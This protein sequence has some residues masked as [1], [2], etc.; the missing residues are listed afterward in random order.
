MSRCYG[1]RHTW[2]EVEFVSVSTCVVFTVLLTL[3]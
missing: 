1:I 3:I 2:I